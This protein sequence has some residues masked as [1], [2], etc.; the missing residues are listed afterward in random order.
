MIRK[1]FFILSLLLVLSF[2]LH[3]II[4]HNHPAEF[5]SQTA[6][7]SENKKLWIS[8]V[9]IAVLMAFGVLELTTKNISGNNLI[10]KTYFRLNEFN[11]T[12]PLRLAI[13]RGLLAPKLYS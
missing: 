10:Y 9:A 13:Y 12:P 6:F 2:V 11:I 1:A 7:H 8:L 3:P 4:P 5:G